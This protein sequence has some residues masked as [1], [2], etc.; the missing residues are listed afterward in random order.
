LFEKLA[1]PDFDAHN[2]VHVRL[3]KLS[4]QA[5]EATEHDQETDLK[6]IV[7]ELEHLAARTWNLTDDELADVRSSLL[8]K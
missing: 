5:H 7:D 6:G 4:Q 2:K 1:I 3:S 8:E